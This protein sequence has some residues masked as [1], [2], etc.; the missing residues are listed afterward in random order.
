MTAR[1]IKRCAG[2]RHDKPRAEFYPSPNTPDGLSYHCLDC[3]AERRTKQTVAEQERDRKEAAKETAEL[4]AEELLACERMA[5]AIVA[6]RH[7]ELASTPSGEPLDVPMQP[8]D[9]IAEELNLSPVRH[10]RLCSVALDMADAM[11]MEEA[12]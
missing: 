11:E 10:H 1:R 5:E 6:H 2:C 9:E 7:G 8:V 3:V 4:S 12:A